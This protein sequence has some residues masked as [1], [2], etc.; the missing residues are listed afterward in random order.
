MGHKE[1][2][3]IEIVDILRRWLEGDGFRKIAMATGMDRN[4]VRKYIR[5]AEEKGVCIDFN[6]DLDEIAYL[7][8]SEVHPEKKAR[9]ENKRD[10]I[11]LPHKETITEW[12]E[13]KKLTLTKVHIK[14]Q[15]MGVEVSYSGLYRFS[16][17]H[18]GFG[19]MR[20]QSR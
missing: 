9:L 12:L 3:L 1:Y 11:L 20:K 6:G 2:N 18:I 7:I 15:R 14:L 17:E 16:R 10:H 19:S 8:F 13:K 4:T 5:I